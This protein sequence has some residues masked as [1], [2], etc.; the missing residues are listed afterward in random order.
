MLIK[1]V[2]KN[3]QVS[4]LQTQKWHLFRFMVHYTTEIDCEESFIAISSKIL[5]KVKK[6]EGQEVLKW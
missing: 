3:Y 1:K 6:K 4:G 2:N 5:Q